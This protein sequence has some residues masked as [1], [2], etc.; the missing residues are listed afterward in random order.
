MHSRTKHMINILRTASSAFSTSRRT[1]VGKIK[2][3][4]ITV[5]RSTRL[6]L[7]IAA[8]LA[9]I[10]FL[11]PRYDQ[12]KRNVSINEW[13][14][15]LVAILGLR[16][17]IFGKIPC[18]ASPELVVSNHISWLDVFALNAEK[19]VRF[20]AKSEISTWPI[21]GQLCRGTGTLFIKR[22]KKGD[23]ARIS[24]GMAALLQ[25]GENVAFFPEGTSSDGTSILPFRSSLLQSAIDCESPIQPIYLRY[26]TATGH[27]TSVAAYCDSISF[28]SS[29]WRLLTSENITIE[30]HFLPKL[31]TRMS[32][33][34]RK[35]N[36]AI[37]SNIREIQHRLSLTH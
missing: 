14:A 33:D 15:K 25:G 19:P 3:Q 13:S 27:P 8:G 16:I 2:R 18:T 32:D 35:L 20:V 21:I 6:C 9:K 23:T 5:I 31:M 29:L 30:L 36:H 11:L 37:E 28:V 24:Q 34:R 1:T 7:H 17:K 4:G 12:A 26:V 10:A 22:S